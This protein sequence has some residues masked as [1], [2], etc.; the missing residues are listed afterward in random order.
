LADPS[1]DE[2]F[3]QLARHLEQCAECRQF[4]EASFAD[5]PLFDLSSSRM[6]SAPTEALS[7]AIRNLKALSKPHDETEPAWARTTLTFLQPTQRNG[8]IGKLGGYEI[9]R[10]VGQG[11]MGVVLEALDPRL[12]RTVAIKVLAPWMLTDRQA[13][14]R[15][16]REAQA[17]A[18]LVHEN[19]VMIHSV[20]DAENVPFLVLEFI[21]GESLGARTRRNALGA[22]PPGNE[23]SL[24][25]QQ[26]TGK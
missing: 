21:E 20:D 13:K 10:V 23:L 12:Q 8:F 15:F 7:T 19:V 2:K 14:E 24:I 18:R 11:G 9:R 26:H 4:L 25:A 6:R 22:I 1:G 17:A 5:D 16:L 3:E